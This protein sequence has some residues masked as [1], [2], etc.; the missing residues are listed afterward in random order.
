MV[1]ADLA[2]IDEEMLSAQHALHDDVCRSLLYLLRAQKMDLLEED[3]YD[4]GVGCGVHVSED[5]CTEK[6]REELRVLGFEANGSPHTHAH[7]HTHVLSP[8]VAHTADS[9]SALK[10]GEEQPSELLARY[11]M[12]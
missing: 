1:L 3:D 11:P 12:L 2:E 10:E 8:A 4:C 9:D 5:R 6:E 7:A